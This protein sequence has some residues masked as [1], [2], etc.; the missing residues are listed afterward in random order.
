MG[1]VKLNIKAIKSPLQMIGFFLAWIETALAASLWPV[2]GN[3]KLLS[4]LLFSVVG[5]AIIIALS[6]VF[7]L[8]YIVKHYPQWLFNPADYDPAVQDELFEHDYS[9]SK[10]GRLAREAAAA[11]EEFDG[12]DHN[13]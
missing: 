5:I 8:V 7:V 12:G 4:I 9:I 10:A 3:E 1:K 6:L 13:G 2:K 11:E